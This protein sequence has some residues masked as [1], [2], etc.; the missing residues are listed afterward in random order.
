MNRLDEIGLPL[1]EHVQHV[2]HAMSTIAEE[3]GL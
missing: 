1:E 2:I 3:L